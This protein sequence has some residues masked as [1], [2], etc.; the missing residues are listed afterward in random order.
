MC[1]FIFAL[2]NELKWCLLLRG[3]PSEYKHHAFREL[4]KANITSNSL[5]VYI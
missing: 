2:S 4:G 5:D 3:L 1:D